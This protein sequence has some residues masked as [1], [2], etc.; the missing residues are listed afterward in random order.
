MST[1]ILKAL[2]NIANNPVYKIQTVYKNKNRANT[3]GDALELYVKD[4]LAGTFEESS[5]EKIN[6]SY[7][8]SFSYLGNT[9]N[10]PDLIIRG[11]DAFEVKK[12]ESLRS[13]I[14]LNSSY[15]KNK[16]YSSDTRITNECRNCENDTDGWSEK[17]IVYTVGNIENENLK[18]LWFVYGSC[19]SANKE[20][21]ERVATSIK[22]GVHDI[23]DIE[24]TTTNELAKINK[25]DPLGI[26]YLRVRGMWGIDNP[27]NVY[28]YILEPKITNTFNL[29]AIIPLEKYN[30]FP[31]I[32]REKIENSVLKIEDKKIKDPNNPANL[33]NIKL[34]TYEFNQ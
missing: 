14:A 30:T 25:V 7:S 18:N 8:E 20:T 32:D 2:I 3:M 19:Y 5:I 4:S 26:T 15:P 24:F 6:Q 22:N 33:I 31:I 1:N 12:T 16:L 28:S 34:I 11:G 9:N 10:P 21:Y 13:S 29:I 23:P 27:I 17:D